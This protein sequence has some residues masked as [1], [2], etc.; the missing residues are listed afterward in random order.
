MRAAHRVAEAI[1]LLQEREKNALKHENELKSSDQPLYTQVIDTFPPNSDSVWNEI[2]LLQGDLPHR[3]A[4]MRNQK[5]KPFWLAAVKLFR[6]NSLLD[7]ST[8]F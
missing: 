6:L 7:W 5:F 2:D 1:T 8:K 3:G 4:A